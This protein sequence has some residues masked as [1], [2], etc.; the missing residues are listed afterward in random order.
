MKIRFIKKSEIAAAS[1]IVGL[2]WDKKDIPLAKRE[3]MA[4][5]NSKV[6]APKYLVAEEKG[7]IAGIAGYSQSW[8]DYHV[9]NIFWVNV[10]PNYQNRG[11]GSYLILKILKEIK[12]HKGENKALL[13]LLSTDKPDFYT[14]FGF[15][16]I[17][18]FEKGK[19]NLMALELL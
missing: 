5:F 19:S 17:K 1:K 9:Y 10:H 13:I 16:S 18:N 2:N 12:S 3:M 14:K 8:M 4:M 11:V 7:N 15:K 6:L